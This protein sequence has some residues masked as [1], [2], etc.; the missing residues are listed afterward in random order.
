ME[1]VAGAVI[2]GLL[3]VLAVNLASRQNRVEHRIKHHLAARNPEF[4]REL[5]L[6]VGPSFLDG[7]YIE[8]LENGNAIFPAMLA[9]IRRAQRTINFETFIY[10]SGN[11]GREF[12]E[13]LAERAR[14][15]VKVHVVLDWLG[16]KRMD[17]ELLEIMEQAG[18][19][20]VRFH[21]PHW[22]TIARMNNRTHRKLLIVDGTVG[23]TGG[24]GIADE[25]LG[26]AEDSGHWRDSHYKVE[27]PVVG[28]IQAAFLENWLEVTGE[29]LTGSDYFPKCARAGD[30]RMQFFTSSPNGGDDSM[31]LMY[32]LSIAA[33]EQSLDIAAAYFL[34]DE[35]MCK[36]LID[37]RQRGVRVRVL[38]P[39]EHIDRDIV[40]FASRDD[41]GPLLEAG[42]EIYEFLPTMLHCKLLVV[43]R[44]VTS[45]GSTNFDPRSMHLNAEANLNVCDAAFASRVTEV[46][47]GDLARSRRIHIEEWAR[48]PL[49]EKLVERISSLLQPQL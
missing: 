14:A 36:L 11:I 45:V 5:E 23:F 44:L 38:V 32:L 39:G 20:V 22:Y 30:S 8:N 42:I 40:R 43:D 28:Q 19:Q 35:L 16:S 3:V 15:G 47:E 26:D 48:R 4:L 18:A 24:V 12:A 41:W 10:W 34:P 7:N 9:A 29:L 25:W 1:F 31:E 46:F 33:A 2:A 49:R 6:L 17:Q 37:A 27:G 21:R 13:A